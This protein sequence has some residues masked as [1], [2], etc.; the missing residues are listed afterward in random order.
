MMVTFDRCQRLIDAASKYA[1]MSGCTNNYTVTQCGI[2]IGAGQSECQANWYFIATN[3][4]PLCAAGVQ[5][6]ADSPAK[7]SHFSTGA[8]R[9]FFCRLKHS[10]VAGKLEDKHSQTLPS[11][12]KKKGGFRLE[13]RLRVLHNTFPAAAP[14][15]FMMSQHHHGG[16]VGL[17][18][19]P[20]QCR[21]RQRIDHLS[22]QK[23]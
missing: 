12:S 9:S 16:N 22:E 11:T 7:P 8:R 14:A 10:R 3:A 19:H 5:V 20:T 2:H 21:E 18:Q 15:H 13:S 6:Q 1:A 4:V 17:C 23:Q